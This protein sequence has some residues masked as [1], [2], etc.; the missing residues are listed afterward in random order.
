MNKEKFA[1][2]T[3]AKVYQGSRRL[4]GRTEIFPNGPAN[5]LNWVYVGGQSIKK[6]WENA[7]RE[8]HDACHSRNNADHLCSLCKKSGWV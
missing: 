1:K 3:Y 2:N 8:Q 6:F 4:T 7:N 5:Q